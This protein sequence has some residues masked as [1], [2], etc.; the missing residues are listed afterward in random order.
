[1]KLDQIFAK[2]G[3][4]ILEAAKQNENLVVMIRVPTQNPIVP[5]RW[6]AWM[7]GV[8]GAAEKA[9]AW[10]VDVSKVF[11]SERGQMKYRWRIIMRGD[12]KKA[13]HMCVQ[14]AVNS[15]R[16]GVEVNEVE[17]IGQENLTPDPRNGKFRGVYRRG[18]Q[19]VA[20][21]VVASAFTAIG[22]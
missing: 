10:G 1:M 14:A 8:L 2:A 16:T 17:L 4:V 11:Y 12:I 18:E 22:G 21:Q 20:S 5:L 3:F 7:D 13:Q 19:D 9:K 6:K 15:L